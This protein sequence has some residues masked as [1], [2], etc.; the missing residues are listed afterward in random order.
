MR[1]DQLSA[2][3]P[4]TYSQDLTYNRLL[5]LILLLVN[6]P[7]YIEHVLLTNQ[8][9]YQKSHFQRHLLGPLLGNGLLTS[10]GD[11]HRRQRR[12]AAPA[13]HHRRIADYAP[14]DGRA[15]R[16]L[17]AGPG[18]TASPSTSPTR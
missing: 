13:F 2:I 14:R 3:G 5:F 16:A 4:E 11:F 10:E 7:E 15:R 8:A 17:R 1:K 9:N 12:L 18:A 6:K